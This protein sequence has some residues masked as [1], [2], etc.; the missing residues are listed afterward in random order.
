MALYPGPSAPP[1]LYMGGC[2]PINLAL[3][4]SEALAW[5]APAPPSCPRPG[6]RRVSLVPP[7]SPCPAPFTL[8]PEPSHGATSAAYTVPA[9]GTAWTLA[10]GEV[11]LSAG[12]LQLSPE[13]S[14]PAGLVVRRSWSPG[15]FSGT[16]QFCG[17]VLP[18]RRSLTS[19]FSTGVRHLVSA[20]RPLWPCGM[21]G[22]V[23][24]PPSDW[25]APGCWPGLSSS[26]SGAVW[27]EGR[28]EGSDV[29]KP[30]P[31]FPGPPS[32]LPPFP[33]QEPLSH[34]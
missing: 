18:S 12:Q 7:P 10:P 17:T 30:P 2:E 6:S 23:S 27:E 8:E 1:Y 5:G 9:M 15:P 33:S 20:G 19:W 25:T 21:Q 31:P 14:L 24:K 22:P 26:R 29:A 28:W 32:R 13:E 3:V 34:S 16:A 11:L 4:G